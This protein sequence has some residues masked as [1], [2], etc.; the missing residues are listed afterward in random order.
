MPSW[1]LF[2]QP[3]VV[4]KE[5]KTTAISTNQSLPA[6]EPAGAIGER[7]TTFPFGLSFLGMEKYRE[8]TW[9]DSKIRKHKGSERSK[10]CRELN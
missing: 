5:A 1:K 7:K 9:K 3:C 10:D 6:P 8:S 4:N 2:Q